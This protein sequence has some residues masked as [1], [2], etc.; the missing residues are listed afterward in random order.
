MGLNIHV[1]APP[2]F[3]DAVPGNPELLAMLGPRWDPEHDPLVVER[4]DLDPR[5]EQR[6]REIDR[7]DADKI[8]SFPPEKAVRR[9]V[10]LHDQIA[11]ALWSLILET[12]T[13]TFFDARRDLD[14]DPL[15]D[16]HLS[17]ALAGR[18]A[19]RR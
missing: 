14:V 4:L 7:D 18:T 17:A 13:R 11:A 16:A 3:F 9:D 6:L 19:L 1:A 15:F 10:D 5:A 12:Q 8:Q 2:V